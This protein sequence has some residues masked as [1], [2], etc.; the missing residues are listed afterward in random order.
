MKKK[1]SSYGLSD[2]FY[3]TILRAEMLQPMVKHFTRPQH[4][5]SIGRELL[6]SAE[7]RKLAVLLPKAT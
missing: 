3:K 6:R 4:L 2:S 7:R 1:S 5:P